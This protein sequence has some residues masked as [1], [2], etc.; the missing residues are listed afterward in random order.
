MK[1]ALHMECIDPRRFALAKRIRRE[2]AYDLAESWKIAKNGGAFFVDVK[3]LAKKV[4]WTLAF[5][6]V[7]FRRGKK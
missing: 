1:S 2:T 7:H 5:S 3:E 6:I 4:G